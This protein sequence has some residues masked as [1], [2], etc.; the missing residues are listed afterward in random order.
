MIDMHNFSDAKNRAV[1][2]LFDAAGRATTPH[3]KTSQNQRSA[4]PKQPFNLINFNSE[5]DLLIIGLILILYKE[6]TDFLLFLAL[7]YILL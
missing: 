1:Q 5:D 6:S 3:S 2:E 7:I 4:L